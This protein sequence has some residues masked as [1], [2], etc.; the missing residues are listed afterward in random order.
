MRVMRSITYLRLRDDG[1]IASTRNSDSQD[2]EQEYFL[3]FE[4]QA[5]KH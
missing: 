1:R 3:N 2:N 5:E 4:Y